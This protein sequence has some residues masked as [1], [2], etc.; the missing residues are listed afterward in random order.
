MARTDELLG[1]RELAQMLGVSVDTV[2]GM[3][4]RG[5]GPPSWRRGKRVV[6]RRSEVEQFLARERETTL[7]GQLV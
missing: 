5:E 4:H 1:T 7:R 3:R 6:Y 2:Y